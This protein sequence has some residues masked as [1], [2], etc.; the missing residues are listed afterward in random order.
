MGDGLVTWRVHRTLSD[1]ASHRD[2]PVPSDDQA[3]QQRGARVP[4]LEDE[5]LALAASHRLDIVVLV[6][7][8][9]KP[10]AAQS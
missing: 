3:L 6:R 10:C 4:E 7:H 9:A 2:G 8:E 1:K 5:A